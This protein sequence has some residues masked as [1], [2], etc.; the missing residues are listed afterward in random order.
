MTEHKNRINK[1]KENLIEN[2]I[3]LAIIMDPANVFYFTGFNSNPHER[4]LAFILEPKNDKYFLFV[5]ALDKDAAS[6]ESIIDQ[7]ISISDEENDF[8]VLKSQLSTNHKIIN[9][10]EKYMNVHSYQ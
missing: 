7:I 3:D 2:N 8:E 10:E 4:F 9:L 6:N 1:L 5:P